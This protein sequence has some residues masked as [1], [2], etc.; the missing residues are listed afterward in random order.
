[1]NIRHPLS[2]P[3]IRPLYPNHIFRLVTNT[4]QIEQ[5]CLNY[6]NLLYHL[7]YKWIVK[8]LG[9]YNIYT[10]C[11][12]SF[13]Q[14]ILTRPFWIKIYTISITNIF[15]QNHQYLKKYYLMLIILLLLMFYYSSDRLIVILFPLPIHQEKESGASYECHWT[16]FHIFYILN[17]LKD[18]CRS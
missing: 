8:L 6:S 5:N 11:E 16:T 2:L 7:P 12:V 4:K 15:Y 10:L 13:F 17:V 18:P 14:Y 1:M 3:Y 9:Q